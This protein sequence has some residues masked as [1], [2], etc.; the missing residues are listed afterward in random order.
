MQ[1]AFL[2]KCQSTKAM[3]F[4]NFSSKPSADNTGDNTADDSQLKEV[5]IQLNDE[6]ITIAA[7]DAA[8]KTVSDLFAE[9][10]S[11]LGDVDRINRFVAAGR[12]VQADAP[13]ELGVVY[14]GAV[15]SESKGQA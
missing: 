10:G 14:R 4:F 3:G 13:V 2:I 1:C 12:I 15:T 11:D 5:V 6:S 8:G 9:F 7:S